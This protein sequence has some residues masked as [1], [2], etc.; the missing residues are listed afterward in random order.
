ME[1]KHIHF[2]GICGV[3]MSALALAMKKAGHTVTGSDK[4]IYPPIQ[5]IKES[6]VDYYTGWHPEKMTAKGTP[7]LVVVGNV[8]GIQKS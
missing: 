8:A 2:I 5:L 7:D 3:A 6:G 4:G 1:N